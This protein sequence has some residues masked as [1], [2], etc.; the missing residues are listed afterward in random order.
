[1]T[2]VGTKQRI[3]GGSFL[4][5]QRRPEEIFA[6]EDVTDQHRLIGRTAE[7]FMQ[8][9]VVPRARQIEE[10]DPALLREL[11]KKAAE[12]GLSATDT[13][14]KYGGLELDKTP[15]TIAAEKTALTA[16]RPATRGGRA[17]PGE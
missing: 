10:K 12:I 8:Q 13:P 9:E 4:I 5:E 15:S 2:T 3:K 1:M 17:A 16:S 11:L 14:Q 6:P 7:D